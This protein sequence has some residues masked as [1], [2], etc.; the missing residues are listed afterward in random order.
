METFLIATG[1]V[2]LAE[3]GDKTQLLA[4]MLAARYRQPLPIILGIAAA[5]L[6][7]HA[8]AAFA[9]Q[10]LSGLVSYGILKWGVGLLFIA[11]G[12]WT[13]VPDKLDDKDGAARPERHGVFLTTLISFFLVE[14][15]DKTQVATVALA[16]RYASLPAIVM[17]TTVG[18][19]L[20]NAPVVFVGQ[21]F[22]DRLPLTWIRRA[23]AAVFIAL[24]LWS[25]LA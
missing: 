25:I 2:A 16:A 7:N 8:L 22:A 15:G 6:L 17:G 13:L 18:M 20:A 24:G 19:L 21:K 3:L 23:A 14:M 9:G 11:L 1:L 10:W 5:T 12:V 4:L